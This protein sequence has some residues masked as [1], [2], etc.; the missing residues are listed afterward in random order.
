MKR[1]LS[2]LTVLPVILLI[3]F[4]EKLNGKPYY[5]FLLV[6]SALFIIFISFVYFEKSN[7]GIKDISIIATLGSIAAVSRVPFATIP[8]IQPVTFIVAL[9]G[10]V[11]GS[12]T[13]FLIGSIAA[14]VSNIFLGQGPWT[15][16]QMLA[17]GTVGAISGLFSKKK[18]S[19]EV[20][21]IMCFFF[22]F[23]FGFIMNLWCVL[24][25]VRVLNFKSIFLTYLNAVP[26]D[27]AHSIGNFIFSIIF[28]DKFY[29]ILMRFYRK[30]SYIQK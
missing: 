1:L 21:S 5:G 10:Y 6:L 23:L 11:F 18:L 7:K 3:I 26:F 19:V 17:W 24:G 15:V 28:Y 9:S 14:F 8:N 27:L 30:I 4:S 20:F 29:K 22:G 2:F 13:G 16:W 12:Y 25:F